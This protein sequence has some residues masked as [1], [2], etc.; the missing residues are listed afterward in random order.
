MSRAL[1]PRLLAAA[2]AALACAT[3][4]AAQIDPGLAAT[5][6]MRPVGAVR[7]I[8][9]WKDPL[10]LAPLAHDLGREPLAQR[11]GRL[12]E[13]LRERF[14]PRAQAALERLRA[15]G[16]QDLQVLW[17]VDAVAAEMPRSKVRE[18]AA[19]PEIDRIELDVPLRAQQ[20]ARA[21]ARSPDPRQAD[22]AAQAALDQAARQGAAPPLRSADVAPHLVAMDVPRAWA[23]GADGRGGTVAV[24]DSGVD[25][26]APGLAAAWRGG[27]GWLDPYGEHRLPHDAMGHGTLVASLLVGQ[28]ADGTPF[29]IAPR[30]RFVAARLYDDSGQG[31]LSAVYRIYQWLL[32]PDGRADTAD[33]PQ[34]VNNSWGF[35]QTSDRCDLKLARVWEAF[36]LAGVAVVFAAGN[37]GP[38]PRTSLSPAN[39]PGVVSVG[40]LDGQGAVARQ[41]SRGPSACTRQGTPL[42][43]PTLHAPGVALPALDRIGSAM[44][45]PSRSDGTS[46]ASAL[47]S[48][49]LLVLRQSMPEAGVDTLLDT[50][51]RSAAPASGERPPLAQLA[52]AV[53]PAQVLQ[54][55]AVRPLHRLALP[56]GD[57]VRLD[58]GSLAPAL[59]RA[60]LLK[61]LT[62]VEGQDATPGQPDA[63]EWRVGELA[64]LRLRATLADG[65]EQPLE[66]VGAPRATAAPAAPT[67]IL[68]ARRG[69]PLAI[70]LDELA[71]ADP[72]A[73][74]W[75]APLR[76]GRLARGSDGVLRYRPPGSFVGTDQ[77]ALR[78][79]GVGELTVKV[80]VRP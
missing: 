22:S 24:V 42:A 13:R 77:F 64:V 1:L 45:V 59:P 69:T 34:V 25:L 76:G 10:A 62:V 37:D 30:A 63:V 80:M 51:A 68:E 4:G 70:A 66:L 7:V 54:A 60:A 18:V 9:H 55:A 33:A 58:A 2:A 26:R 5:M 79:P 17:L 20:A 52:T 36:R 15:L 71:G 44:G 32:D 29:G 14:A 28:G 50:L 78:A 6:A 41:S 43:F 47:A 49:A 53:L 48:G 46:F 74:R 67:R 27:A 65:S 31:R 72:A 56:A 38:S 8:V 73:V 19:W 23:G 21:A 57:V 3:A 11:P 12:A 75:S 61:A 16:A 39:N 35:A 40:A